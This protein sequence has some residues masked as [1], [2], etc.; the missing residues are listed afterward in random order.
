MKRTCGR[1]ASRRGRGASTPGWWLC[2]GP[3]AQS[4]EER[5]GIPGG[6]AGKG[7]VGVEPRRGHRKLPSVGG[8][9]NKC[10]FCWCY[11]MTSTCRRSYISLLL[12]TSGAS[13]SCRKE[14]RL[15]VDRG[16]GILV[17]GQRSEVTGV[18][19]PLW[20]LQWRNHTRDEWDN[21]TLKYRQRETV[22]RKKSVFDLN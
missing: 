6:S 12:T 22:R 7:P 20:T 5:I 18:V 11:K 3:G 2:P 16:L 1:A 13:M 15:R 19:E 17:N 14:W 9:T 21:S 4:E 8:D 10:I